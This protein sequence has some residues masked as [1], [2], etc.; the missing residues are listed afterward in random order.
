M[1]D[2]LEGMDAEWGALKCGCHPNCGIGTM[3]LVNET[4]RQAVPFPQIVNADRLLEDMQEITD[5]ARSK[6][7]TVMQFALSVLRNT[8]FSELPDGL[9]L[10]DVIKVIDGHNGSRLGLANKSR[11]NWRII[12]IAGMWFQDL[13]NYDFRRTE[14]CIIP[15]ATQLGEVSFCAYNTGVGWRQIVEKMFSTHSTADWF[16]E[17]GRHQI[18]AAGK[19]VPMDDA[20]AQPTPVTPGSASALTASIPAA[21][22]GHSD[23]AGC[24]SERVTH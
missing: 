9:G 2:L 1:R 10:W 14:M 6:P 13:F 3:L 19:S 23:G 12:L 21:L 15:Y 22:H 24:G 4:T 8:R 11:Y 20:P 18:F 16:K 5:A 17:K 7:L